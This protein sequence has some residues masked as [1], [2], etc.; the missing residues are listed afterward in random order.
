MNGSNGDYSDDQSFVDVVNTL[1]GGPWRTRRRGKSRQRQ[2]P[3]PVAPAPASQT[4]ASGHD[5]RPAEPEEWSEPALG[6]SVARPYTWTQGRTAPVIDLGVETLVSTTEHGHD[7]AVLT[8][9]EHRAVAEL[10]GDPRSVAEVAALLSLPLGVARV[11]LADMAAIGLVVVHRNT[12]SSA[13]APDMAL[14]ERVLSG[15]RRL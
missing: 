6:A 11:V 2:A 10:C 7:M 1:S 9:A 12:Y 5:E 14:M 3:P 15:L 13:D 8:C 4:P